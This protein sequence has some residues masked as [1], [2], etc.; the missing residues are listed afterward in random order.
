MSESRKAL[1]FLRLK[2][3]P[4]FNFSV[5]FRCKHARQVFNRC[6]HPDLLRMG[7]AVPKQS[8]AWCK[9]QDYMLQIGSNGIVLWICEFRGCWSIS[10]HSRGRN[11][12][13][14]WKPGG[15]QTIRWEICFSQSIR[16]IC[17][18]PEES[19]FGGISYP[20]IFK[21]LYTVG[22]LWYGWAAI[23]KFDC[24]AVSSVLPSTV[25]SLSSQ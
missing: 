25:Y 4:S 15:C 1:I 9:Q 21:Y 6:H 17:F 19:S 3:V 7:I 14:G 5:N 20:I 11:Y 13:E 10:S 8:S 12:F 24:P 2:H 22:L 16:L 18:S 23:Y